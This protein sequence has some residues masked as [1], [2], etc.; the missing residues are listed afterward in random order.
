MHAFGSSFVGMH[1]LWWMF[2]VI[3]LGA[4][5]S[6]FTPVPRRLAR[7]GPRALDILRRRYAAG[8][9]SSEEYEARKTILERDE[10]GAAR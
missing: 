4:A 9:I 6:M 10:P 2:W 8:R 1:L 7:T 5:F 3:A